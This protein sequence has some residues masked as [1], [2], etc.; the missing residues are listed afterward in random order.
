MSL[1]L[2]SIPAFF[3]I[4]AGV[5]A[6]DNL[7]EK[8]ADLQL[9]QQNLL[10]IETCHIIKYPEQ[11]LLFR[12][13]DAYFYLDSVGLSVHKVPLNKS[14]KTEDDLAKN[15]IEV[16][17]TF[18]GAVVGKVA[19]KLASRSSDACMSYLNQTNIILKSD[20]AKLCET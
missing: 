19:A 11:R 10:R 20:R 7:S 1:V 14:V 16:Y 6:D 2:A 17:H 5:I 9:C 4:I 3:L 15:S 18:S 8:I 13:A 12:D